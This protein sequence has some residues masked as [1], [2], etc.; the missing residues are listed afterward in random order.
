MSDTEPNLVE[1][2]LEEFVERL[3]SGETPSIADYEAAYPACAKQ[4]RD[5]FPAA[6]AMQH[7]A[8]RRK[9]ACGPPALH[10]GMPEHSGDYRLVRQ[11]G[12]GGM[13]IVYEAE[14]GTLGRR[15][16]VKVLPRSALSNPQSLHRFQRK[17]RTAARL[18]HSNIIPVFGVGED[19]GFHYIVM[20]L[21]RGVGL[22]KIIRQLTRDYAG[23][24]QISQT[25]GTGNADDSSVVAQALLRGEFSAAT[26][27]ASTRAGAKPFHESAPNR[28]GAGR[29]NGRKDSRADC[30]R[31]PP[32]CGPPYWASV[33]RIG[34]QTAEAL[35]YAHE[36]GTLH[37]DI[38]PANL[39]LD[40]QGRVWVGDFGLAKAQE[41]DDLSRTGDLAGT[42]R[43]MP[44]E[45]FSGAV[46]ARGDIY[47]LGLSLYE[48]LTLRPAYDDCPPGALMQRITT[49]GPVRLQTV[50][51][52]IPADLETIILKAIAPDPAH[53]YASAR[54][55]A[56][57]LQRFLEDRPIQARCVSAVERLWRWS[58]RNRDLAALMGL[59][60]VLLILVAVVTSVGYVRGQIANRRVSEA[61]NRESQQRQFAESQQHKAE[62]M[63]AL[64]QGALDEIFDQFVPGP[65][66]HGTETSP[67]TLPGEE[68][69][70]PA[71]PVLS[72]EAAAPLERMLAYYDRLAEQEAEDNQ[73][74][75]KVA[76]A[77][78][79]VGDIRRRLGHFEQSR[80][81]YLQAIDKYQQLRA[82]SAGR[83]GARRG[84]GKHL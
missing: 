70:V 36:H 48:M 84:D 4:I 53:R 34:L 66:T 46:D 17:A 31:E 38:K 75:R 51:P 63:A 37:R 22:D 10:A 73:L 9:V 45:R 83:Y 2:L 55:L 40:L 39:L 24:A 82:Q 69:P 79:R 72:K 21:I 25:L 35:Q 49:E 60:A 41:H 32:Q 80:T 54:E 62:A 81:A 30:R 42:L 44:P 78:R 61:L 1:R 5:L 18:H 6:L 19:R 16:A 33:A 58:R 8:A 65:I 59:A 68:F 67:Y 64:T 11:I 50:N 3:Q 77:N 27:A 15:V 56:D 20:Q 47:S 28:Y 7:V 52:H 29:P 57:D 13:G 74:R 14:Q 43:Y 23:G 26:P 12:C 76:D 71:Q